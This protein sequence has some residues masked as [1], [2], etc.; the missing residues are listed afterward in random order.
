V[1]VPVGWDLAEPAEGRFND[2][3]IRSV[4]GQVAAAQAAG[5]SVV[6]D[7]GIQYAPQ[8]VMHLDA[9]SQFTDQYGQRFG[10]RP[11]SG[12]EVPNAVTDHDVRARLQAYLRWLGSAFDH[13]GFYAVRI[14]GGP[15]G[16]L[17]YPPA[18][19]DG[20]TDCFWAFDAASQATYAVRGW[21]RET[22]TAQQAGSFLHTYDANLAAYGAWL[23]GT[24]HSDFPGANELLLLP[25]WGERPGDVQS[26]AQT[27][28]GRGSVELNSGTDWPLQL[29]EVPYKR[30]TI[31]YTTW[32]DGPS[33][34]DNPQEEDPAGYLALLARR[35]GV[36]LGG[37]DTGGGGVA[38]LQLSLYRAI[39]L[40]FTL[41]DWVRMP[42][43]GLVGPGANAG[44]T[45]LTR[46]VFV[47]ILYTYME[48]RAPG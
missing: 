9:S 31:A 1:T 32:L 45:P 14:G 23:D 19:Y 16:E 3:Y 42:P 25:G 40:R 5:L 17:R 27:R 36:R 2:A 44:P 30:S 46:D 4:Q 48:P 20:H 7:L 18:S 39:T 8:W 10:G 15:D 24:A 43:A 22:S 28:L 21:G 29:A 38:D 6:L 13:F 47:A 34:G 41:V 33:H 12:D 37:E 26:A 35:T 11:A